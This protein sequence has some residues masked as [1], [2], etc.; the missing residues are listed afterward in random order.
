MS[1]WTS[2]WSTTQRRAKTWPESLKHTPPSLQ[3]PHPNTANDS[4]GTG[5]GPAP[6]CVGALGPPPSRKLTLLRYLLGHGEVLSFP[7]YRCATSK[8]SG[9]KGGEM[10]IY[11]TAIGIHSE[12]QRRMIAERDRRGGDTFISRLIERG[13]RGRRAVD[14]RLGTTDRLREGTGS[15]PLPAGHRSTRL[16]GQ[17]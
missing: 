9:R 7:M 14:G 17:H 2:G 1:G 8:P 16:R 6:G 10:L 3:H 15:R 11:R 13:A 12:K 5:T 4:D